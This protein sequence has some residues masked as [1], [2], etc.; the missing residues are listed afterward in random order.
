MYRFVPALASG[1]AL[2]TGTYPVLAQDTPALDSVDAQVSYSIGRQIGEQLAGQA[3]D[4]AFDLDA[5][6]L[7]IE[8]ALNGADVRL[9][10]AQLQAAF[11]AV[12]ARR[13]SAALTDGQAF[14][15]ENA[16]KAGVITTDSG[17]QY[18]VVTA[19]TGASPTADQTV[20]VHYEGRLL[21][22]TVFDSSRA[23]NEPATFPVGGVIAGWQ[24]A[25][26]LMAPGATWE[27]W[28]PSGLAYGS[29]GAGQTI[30]PNE[31]L[32]FTI[33]LISIDG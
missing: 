10:T 27:V 31:V 32:N 1:L 6:T 13:D 11:E 33:E 14:L 25:L 23:R 4:V 18:T 15:D 28:I 5:L 9:S 24:E 30:G 7:G 3:G 22:G 16:D 20:T 26:Q 21:N 17:L 19:G 12:Q 2:V 29:Q 8:D